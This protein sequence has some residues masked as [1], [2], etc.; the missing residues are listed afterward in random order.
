MSTRNLNKR[1]AQIEQK[2]QPKNNGF[3]CIITDNDKNESEAIKRAMEEL[4][5]SEKPND[6][7]LTLDLRTFKNIN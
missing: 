7:S 6:Y 1:V 4:N 5:Y 2:I 3:Y